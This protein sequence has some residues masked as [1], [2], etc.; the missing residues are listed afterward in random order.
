MLKSIFRI[1]SLGKGFQ[2]AAL[3]FFLGLFL[4]PAVGVR[5]EAYEIGSYRVHMVLGEDRSCQVTEDISMYFDEERQGIIRTLPHQ[6]S[7][8]SFTLGD[9]NVVGDPFSLE[10]YEDYTDVRI[11]EAGF[12]FSG[13]KQYSIKFTRNYYQDFDSEYDWFYTDLIPGDWDTSIDRGEIT[14]EL[15]AQILDYTL[16]FAPVGE[17]GG[18]EDLAVE[19]NDGVMTVKTLR[20]VEN[21][22]A[23]TLMAKFPEGTFWAAPEKVY[24]Y[25]VADYQAQSSLDDTGNLHVREAFT[26]DFREETAAV[27]YDLNLEEGVNGWPV[28]LTHFQMIEGEGSY[29]A[30]GET[31]TISLYALDGNPLS[32]ER[33]FIVEYD[34]VFPADGNEGK[35]LFL[36]QFPGIWSCPVEHAV[37]EMELPVAAL[38]HQ[39]LYWYLGDEIGS[40]AK[41][42]TVAN[43]STIV[44]TGLDPLTERQSI[45]FLLEFPD[46]T[47]VK[48][49]ALPERIGILLALVFAVL[50]VFFYLR[51]GRD[52][53]L[54]PVVEFYPP[55]GMNP[56][57]VGY[58]IDRSVETV[59]ATALIFYWASHGHLEIEARGK[60]FTLHLKSSLDS[61]HSA[62]EK[63][64]FQ[65]LWEL[66]N[67]RS[68]DNGELEGKY[69]L[70]ILQIKR[71]VRAAFKKGKALQDSKAS[72]FAFLSFFF[73]I[74]VLPFVP[75][76]AVY[77]IGLGWSGAWIAYGIAFMVFGLLGFFLRSRADRLQKY[78]Y[79]RGAVRRAGGTL[80]FTIIF[81]LVIFL[82]GLFFSV[83]EMK[84]YTVWICL[85]A[86]FFSIL[87]SVFTTRRS[88]YG[89]AISE[90]IVGFRN[91]LRDAEK[92]KLEALMEENPEY[93]Y[94]IL[95]YA[96]VLGVTKIWGEKFADLSLPPPTWYHQNSGDFTTMVFV[97]NYMHLANQMNR[98][99][100]TPPKV[101]GG[102]GGGGFSGGGFGGGGFSGGG[103]GGGG[104]SW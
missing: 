62:Y 44:F 23:V 16:H 83:W 99:A 91:F 24:P 33:Q 58:V 98:S 103:G 41:V 55:D 64:A 66:G 10:E 75:M 85:G 40:D 4:L 20:R 27:T 100:V 76:A 39:A 71:E 17:Q 45:G 101:E 34:L 74:L 80:L 6:N 59:D 25:S 87:L 95:P 104:S 54:V 70:E 50:A 53:T 51:Y 36:F 77:N 89:Q 11:G 69:Y 21:G 7:I 86:G 48:P 94:D 46:G 31:G 29:S 47:F 73:G 32:G 57:E 65:K 1:K 3:L 102:S 5:A 72:A 8:E 88:S 19:V 56:A 63:R 84:P 28:R 82:L 12:Y 30:D 42:E 38:S 93:F 61:A 26:V 67:G 96:Q 97:A 14:I 35:D 78:W 60:A 90:R 37:V 13:S 18:A 68:V 15:P 52:E 79:K 92:E 81:V 22:E 49:L 43:D 2:F 9:I